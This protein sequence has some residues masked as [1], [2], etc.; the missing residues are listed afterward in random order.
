MRKGKN[1]PACPVA[2][3]WMMG[4]NRGKDGWHTQCQKGKGKTS[5]GPAEEPKKGKN[6]F[7]HQEKGYKSA[8]SHVIKLRSIDF[9]ST[10]SHLLPALRGSRLIVRNK[11]PA[12]RPRGKREGGKNPVHYEGCIGPPSRRIA[13][14]GTESSTEGRGGSKSC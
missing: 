2:E 12:F 13:Y 8:A 9:G 10:E 11:R 7:S 1:S 4:A 3:G 6:S 14:G 5:D